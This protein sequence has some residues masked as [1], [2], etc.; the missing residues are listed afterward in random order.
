MDTIEEDTIDRTEDDDTS[1]D[2]LRELDEF[3]ARAGS[4]RRSKS[5]SLDSITLE[6][7]ETSAAVEE[8]G[9]VLPWMSLPQLPLLLRPP[10]LVRQPS[11]I[12]RA[13]STTQAVTLVTVRDN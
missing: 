5:N 13:P 4:S 2:A 10:G 11:V 1:D 9:A 8:K 7:K 3:L 6:L 12:S